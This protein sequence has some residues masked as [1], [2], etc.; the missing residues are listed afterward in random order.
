M[1]A[2]AN[3]NSSF[4]SLPGLTPNPFDQTKAQAVRHLDRRFANYVTSV[5]LP[6]LIDNAPDFRTLIDENIRE[7]FP[8]SAIA[9]GRK[10][11]NRVKYGAIPH[12]RVPIGK[13][14]KILFRKSDLDF[15]F[16]SH[17]LPAISQRL[18]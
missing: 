1:Q 6:N 7:E 13:N 4:L 17:L 2:T 3:H 12:K 16:D 11:G 8:P 14:S 10:R 9:V 18:N 15:W 5:G